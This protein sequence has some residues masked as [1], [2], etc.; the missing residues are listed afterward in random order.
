[1]SAPTLISFFLFIFPST[2]AKVLLIHRGA[3]IPAFFSPWW[4]SVP[5]G[6]RVELTKDPKLIG[7]GGQV[8]GRIREVSGTEVRITDAGKG[9]DRGARAPNS[10]RPCQGD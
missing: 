9:G 2:A 8:I 1:L 3:L 5:A 6:T 4:S 7:K 10:N